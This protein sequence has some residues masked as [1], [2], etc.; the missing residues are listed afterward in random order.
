MRSST[1]VHY[2]AL[3]HL[4]AL[5][6][7][8]VFTWHF[9]HAGQ[10]YPIPFEGAPHLFPL[11]LL[12]EGHA[13][14]AL[15][16]A[17]SGYLFAKLLDGASIRYGWFLYNRLLRLLPILIVAMLLYVALIYWQNG[18]LK[19]VWRDIRRG[20]LY[21]TL[22]NGGWSITV[23]LHFYLVLP[24]LLLID[25]HRPWLLF[26]LIAV[27]VCV[28]FYLHTRLGEIQ[29]LSYW[30]IVGRIDQFTFGIIA[31]RYRHYFSRGWLAL[32]AAIAFSA[33]YWWFDAR[34]GF[35]QMPSYPSPS[36]LWIVLPSIEGVIFGVLIAWY[37][38]R[39]IDG[40]SV[41]SRF[42]GQL[43]AYSYSIYL[44]HFFVVFH[45]AQFID[46]EVMPLNNFYVACIW[47]LL[48]FC[49]MIVPGYLS[50]RFIEGP[51]LRLRRRYIVQKQ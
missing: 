24:L 19:A 27:F 2:L 34:G 43:G 42:I 22:P 5:A 48:V 15:F 4:R 29:T 51:F 45:A 41:M 37:D 49:L 14:V 40:R 21:P 30:T 25:R 1:G 11:A 3:D 8:M 7:F 20:W 38:A 32:L 50:F 35:Y 18:D 47:S 13:G 39:L 12:D 36:R 23:E 46:Q 17:L 9:T 28:R 26:G 44:L 33:F 6:A 16:M 10:G 31:Y